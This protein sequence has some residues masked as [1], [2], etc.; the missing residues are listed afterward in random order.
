VEGDEISFTKGLGI[1]CTVDKSL[2]IIIKKDLRR[3]VVLT[4]THVA[5]QCKEHALLFFRCSALK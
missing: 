5:G 1:M 3:F 2:N 4:A